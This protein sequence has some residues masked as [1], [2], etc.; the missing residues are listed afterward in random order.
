MNVSIKNI[1]VSY[2]TLIG[3]IV[4]SLLTQRVVAHIK[5]CFLQHDVIDHTSVT[6]SLNDI[7]RVNSDQA[8]IDERN[9]HKQRH[10]FPPYR[11]IISQFVTGVLQE[12]QGLTNESINTYQHTIETCFK[13]GK[14]RHPLCISV[15]ICLCVLC[16]P[17]LS[18]DEF[19]RICYRTEN[20]PVEHGWF[21]IDRRWSWCST[22]QVIAWERFEYRRNSLSLKLFHILRSLSPFSRQYHY[23]FVLLAVI[24]GLR[25]ITLPIQIRLA[26]MMIRLQA[27]KHKIENIQILYRAKPLQMAQ[28]LRSLYR[29]NNID[30]T[31]CWL[32]AVLDLIAFSWF[33]LVS[34]QFSVQMSLDGSRLFWAPD[35]V[36]FNTKLVSAIL[37]GIVVVNTLYHREPYRSTSRIIAVQILLYSL[38]LVLGVCWVWPSYVF[39]FWFLLLTVSAVLNKTIMYVVNIRLTKVRV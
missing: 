25:V 24:L 19:K 21:S 3:Y 22:S 29:E 18:G 4:V 20:R 23:L 34:N 31:Y 5:T 26:R 17:T 15:P 36:A 12:R 13:Q 33:L 32:H 39:I 11:R 1:S 16:Q 7:V 8:S 14:K 37:I 30:R 28:K 35:V 27:L 6:A 9:I 10:L 38:I 2:M